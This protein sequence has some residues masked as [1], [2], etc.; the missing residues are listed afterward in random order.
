MQGKYKPHIISERTQELPHTIFNKIISISKKKS[1]ISLGPGE[2][3]F[4]TP[5]NISTAGKRAIDR[6]YTHYTP[7]EGF[8]ELREALAKKLKRFNHISVDDPM[9]SICVT[10]GSTESLLLGLFS[11]IDAN[12]QVLVPDPGFLAYRPMVEMIDAQAISYGLH[13]DNGFQ[14]DIDAIKQLVTPRTKAIVINTPSNPTGTVFNHSLIEEL[15]DLAVEKN[16]TVISD[17]AYESFTFDGE[18]HISIGSLNGMEN[19]VI[20][21]FSFSKTYAMPG[22][23]IGYTVASPKIIESMSRMHIYT[24]LCAPSISQMAALAAITGPQSSVK[25]MCQEYD[26]RRKFILKRLK[27]INCLEVKVQPHGAFYVF[28]RIRPPT[29][30]KSEQFALWLLDKTGVVTVPGTEFGPA[31]EGFIRLS[32]ATRMDLIEES[33][34]RLECLNNIYPKA[35]K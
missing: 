6:G 3:D 21:M 17:E 7:S 13:E 34:N 12:E 15:A 4:S 5:N 27:N 29:H 35:T 22:W 2:P 8:R 26:R 32:Y 33:M 23:R 19:Y 9:D 24:S 18:K 1:V 14:L 30:M 28:P 20:S 16:L 25:K 10:C 11:T 31:G